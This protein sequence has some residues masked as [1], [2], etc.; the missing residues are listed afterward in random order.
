MITSPGYSRPWCHV[1]GSRFIMTAKGVEMR[2]REQSRGHP[3][4][5]KMHDHQ[6]CVLIVLSRNEKVH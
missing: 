2:S 4:A 6:G 5:N 3:L 1:D